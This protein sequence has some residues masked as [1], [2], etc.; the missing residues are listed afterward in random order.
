MNSIEKVQSL[1]IKNNITLN[2]KNLLFSLSAGK[3]SIALFNIFLKIKN[4]INFTMSIFHLNHCLRNEESDADEAFLTEMANVHSIEIHRYR[5]DFGKNQSGSFEEEARSIRYGLINNLIDQYNYDYALTAHTLSDNVET[6]LMRL[7][8]G[9]SI[10][11]VRGIPF[12]RGKVIRPLLSLTKN[13][14]YGYL[15]DNKL[16]WR[17][18]LSNKDNYYTRNYLRNII[19]PE[20]ERR[21]PDAEK[22]VA[23]FAGHADNIYSTYHNYLRNKISSIEDSDRT[24]IKYDQTI[25][26]DE[27]IDYIA[28]VVRSRYSSFINTKILDEIKKNILSEK[29]NCEIYQNNSVKISK[30]SKNGITNILLETNSFNIVNYSITN[31][32]I[33]G[34]TTLLL[35]N[36]TEKPTTWKNIG[37]KCEIISMQQF[38]SFIDPKIIYL[39]ISDNPEI[40]IRSRIDGDKIL[41]NGQHRRLKK[42]YIDRKIALH[43]KKNIPV[44]LIN[45]EVSAVGFS[46]FECGKNMTSDKFLVKSDTKKILAISKY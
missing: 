46:F 19:I 27:L 43:N 29:L 10:Y 34:N 38:K 31:K 23:K 8:T 1:L 14:V 41:I 22:S 37:L 20:I 7:F 13:E 32:D 28:D 5:H 40:L 36:D 4:N 42:V 18:D 39:D 17:E 16:L 21:F 15:K 2:D 30:N 35:I 12:I 9:T 33:A 25:P 11:G 3:D 26:I 6:V 45:N 44:F 24:I